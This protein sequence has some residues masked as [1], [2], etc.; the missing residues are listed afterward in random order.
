MLLKVLIPAMPAN[1]QAKAAPLDAAPAVEA[2]SRT[3]AKATKRPKAK[4]PFS[5][6]NEEASFD[7]DGFDGAVPP[8][9]SFE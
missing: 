8:P 9:V 6:F 5:A 7:D 2:K 4:E 1:S 3:K